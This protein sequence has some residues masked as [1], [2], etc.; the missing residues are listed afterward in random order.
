MRQLIRLLLVALPMVAGAQG[1]AY[2]DVSYARPNDCSAI[3]ERNKGNP[4]AYVIREHCER[5]TSQYKQ[6]VARIYGR[7]QPSTKVLTVPMHGST[8]ATRYGVSCM[9]GLVML[10]IRNGWEQALDSDKRYYTCR[11]P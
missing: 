5:T 4:Y 8:E 11:S 10:R 3:T 1:K 9:G 2:G 7:P 6:D